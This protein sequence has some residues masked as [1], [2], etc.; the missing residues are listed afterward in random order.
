MA[1]VA[2]G[3]R[4]PVRVSSGVAAMQMP[5]LTPLQLQA[6]AFGE[7]CKL[8]VAV[9]KAMASG[10]VKAQV[11]QCMLICG[12]GQWVCA[13]R[14]C[15]AVFFLLCWRGLWDFGADDAVSTYILLGLDFQNSTLG[16]L[17]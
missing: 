16:I 14:L 5:L 2:A 10:F 15:S 1:T 3:C 8:G 7:Q 9:P 13:T 12:L 6:A 17:H 4:Q 11:T